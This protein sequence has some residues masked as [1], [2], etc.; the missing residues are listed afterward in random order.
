MSQASQKQIQLSE[1]KQAP[2]ANKAADSK[3]FE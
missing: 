1:Q 2:T 3:R